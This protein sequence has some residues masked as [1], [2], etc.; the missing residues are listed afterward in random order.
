MCLLNDGKKGK[1]SVERR[2]VRENGLTGGSGRGN[3][4]DLTILRDLRTARK[5]IATA[6][7]MFNRQEEDEESRFYMFSCVRS[8]EDYIDRVKTPVFIKI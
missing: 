2:E 7:E 1:N 4:G 8:I 6:V 5:R 3:I